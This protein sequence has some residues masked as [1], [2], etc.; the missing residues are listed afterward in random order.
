LCF[1][2]QE[3]VIGDVDQD[4]GAEL[5]AFVRE[6]QTGDGANDVWVYPTDPNAPEMLADTQRWHG[7]FCVQ[8]ERC[9]VGDVTGDAKADLVAFGVAVRQGK[10]TYT[11]KLA[12]SRLDLFDPD[13][14][15]Y[16]GDFCPAN[17]VCKLG[18]IDG[19]RSVDVIAFDRGAERVPCASNVR[20]SFFYQ[21]PDAT[22]AS[23]ARAALPPPTAPRT[24]AR[25]KHDAAILRDQVFL[26][27]ITI[28]RT[29]CA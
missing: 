1:G 26:P 17:D 10:V 28:V 13:V 12:P 19:N 7:A 3:C 11:I 20:V 21:A 24:P 18:D 9:M 29:S 23:C 22:C 15:T 4:N 2:E 25:P 16:A 5:I 6:T 14:R 8:N 27:T